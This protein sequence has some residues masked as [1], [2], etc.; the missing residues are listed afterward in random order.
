MADV[1]SLLRQQR[2]M[3]RI[4]HP[5]AVY[6]EAGRLLCT[7]CREQIKADSLWDKHLQSEGHRYRQ[8]D[9]DAAAEQPA[10]HAAAATQQQ[11]RKLDVD[12]G[13]DGEIEEAV[14]R[15]RSKQDMAPAHANG[16][17]KRR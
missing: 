7:L 2:A 17:R 16:A 15:K 9:R 11:K 5:H 8:R 4:E 3:R 13:G 14:R 10:S 1:R 12:D 6:T